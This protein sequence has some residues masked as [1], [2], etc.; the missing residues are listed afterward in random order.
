[1]VES[2]DERRFETGRIRGFADAD[3]ALAYLCVT[4]RGELVGMLAQTEDGVCRERS[5]C[6]VTCL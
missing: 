6:L 5:F 2:A 4:L 1:M 3:L